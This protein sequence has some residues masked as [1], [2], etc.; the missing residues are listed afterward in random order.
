MADYTPITNF[1]VKDTLPVGHADRLI[2]GAEWDAEFAAIS[3]TIATLAEGSGTAVEATSALFTPTWG[4]G[5]S[6][7]PTGQWHYTLIGD[8]THDYAQI[9]APF[10]NAKFG[11]ADANTLT[12]SDIPTAIRP[13]TTVHGFSGVVK[14]GDGSVYAGLAHASITAAGVITWSAWGSTGLYSATGWG[15]SNLKGFPLGYS[16][17]WPLVI[18]S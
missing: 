2:R 15:V 10:R 8:G 5:F 17:M 13:D 14:H 18:T 6:T 11:T 7:N 4:A 3:A 9:N 12:M 1:T 16:L